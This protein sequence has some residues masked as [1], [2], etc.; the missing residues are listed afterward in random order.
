M[1][2]VL[3][4]KAICLVLLLNG[5]NGGQKTIKRS[6]LSIV[7]HKSLTLDIPPSLGIY[8]G[9]YLLQLVPFNEIF[10]HTTLNFR[11]KYSQIIPEASN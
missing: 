8:Q 4:N 2:G 7:I 5:Q 3:I 1:N 9:R 6:Y 10:L 11:V